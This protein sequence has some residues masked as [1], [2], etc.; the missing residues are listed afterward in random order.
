MWLDYYEKLLKMDYTDIINMSI[1]D[2]EVAD[3]LKKKCDKE[4]AK[5]SDMIAEEK[6]EKLFIDKKQE[7][8]LEV[9]K[10]LQE[11]GIKKEGMVISATSSLISKTFSINGNE[12]RPCY[13]IPDSE[14]IYT[15]FEDTTL[16]KNHYSLEWQEYNNKTGNRN[17]VS[18]INTTLVL[19]CNPSGIGKCESIIIMLKG[20]K[21]P[22]IFPN[23][24][25]ST[26]AF[27]SQTRF[28]RKGVKVNIHVLHECFLRDVREC[29]NK[30]FL[31]IPK[32]AG[33]CT[34]QSGKI[35]YI[36]SESVIQGLETLFP[37]EVREHMLIKHSL[38]LEDIASIYKSALPDTV[39]SKL[40][41]I[42]RAES[43]LLPFYEAEGLHSD[44][45]FVLIYSGDSKKEKCIALTKRKNYT[46]TVVQTLTDRIANVRK[47]LD[48]ANDTTVLL[49]FNGIIEDRR[50][51]DNGLKEILMELKRENGKEN[52]TRKLIIL[53]TDLPGILP[54]DYP[55]YYIS[56]NDN[57]NLK[58][59]EVLQRLCGQLDYAIIQYNMNNPDTIKHFVQEGL[60]VARNIVSE[61]SIISVTNTMLMTLATAY[62]LKRLSIVTCD[63]FDAISQWFK[64]KATLCDTVG[65]TVCHEF[66]TTISNAIVSGE[67]KIAKQ[68]GPPY[69]SEDGYTAF[70]KDEDKSININENVIKNIIIS[71]MPIYSQVKINKYLNQEG[72][73]IAKHTSKRKLKV[74]Y[75]E[76]VLDNIEVFSYSWSILS[77]EAKEL[78]NNIIKNEF[79]FNVDE[80][81]EGFVPL[82]YN[83]D[84]TKTAGYVFIPDMD[85]NLHEVYFGATRSGKTFA[86]VN[87][88]L[89]KV[90]FEGANAVVIF[91]QTGGF[92]PT[93]VEKHISKEMREKYFSFWNAYEDGLPV[94]LLDLRGCL[95]YKDKKERLLRVYTM[96]TRTLGSYEEQILKNA[97]KCMLKDM[98]G[99]HEL[100][101]FNLAKYICEEMNEDEKPARDDTHRKLLY[102]IDTVLDDLKGTPQTKSNWG[103]FVKDQGKP[104]VV[105]STGVD[106]I[107]K[108][109]EII[110]ILLENLYQYKQCHPYEKYTV[111]IDE[112]QDLYLHEKGA[113]NT[114]LR[115]GGK[116]GI[117]MFLASQSFPDPKTPFGKVVGNCGRVRGYRPKGDNLICYADRFRCDKQEANALPKGH[118]FDDGQ[119]YSRYRTENVITTLKGKTVAFKPDYENNNYGQP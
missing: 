8:Q 59:I 45:G 67:L 50:A 77:A 43:Y 115:K 14:Q 106:G 49:T 114:L 62:I 28:I 112:A 44:R 16:V 66:M 1:S 68:Y 74:S 13:F 31:I 9:M 70:I 105:I 12:M 110:D 35:T 11:Q 104:I 53:L 87:R 27:K 75:D 57:I 81:P 118:C 29:P 5:R 4:I 46:S 37:K 102:K 3:I 72:F 61:L 111:V 90:K 22:L 7:Y 85:E 17:F 89:F 80:Y 101:I 103:E 60:N 20:E 83:E 21:V 117:I 36:S 107:G 97:I 79:W 100:T 24:D 94:D 113:V 92:S 55:V 54:E 52:N 76:G 56:C 88:A 42:I 95:T 23:G 30:F 91:D 98:K 109:S 96:M 64:E 93:E 25:I 78:V 82:L 48:C 33:W 58:N 41:T 2:Y 26:E 84:G 65:D 63:D 47:E 32:H 19:I 86:T 40:L 15:A 51:I 116:H 18:K 108:G 34:L 73:L 6:A 38:P 99:N 71:K 10:Q 69:Y 39:D 119:F